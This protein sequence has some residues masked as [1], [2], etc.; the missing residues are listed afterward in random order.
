MAIT[1][2]ERVG[3]A[4]DLLRS[5]LG[6]LAERE[7][8]NIHSKWAE[9]VAR[10]YFWT[11]SRLSTN[12]PLTEWDSAAPLGLTVLSWGDAFRQTLGHAERSLV[13]EILDWRNEWAHQRRF[14]GDDAERALDSAVRLLTAISAPQADEASRMR[15]ELR[16]L[17]INEQVELNIDPHQVRQAVTQRES[18]NG[19]V[20]ARL[21]G[22]YCWVLAP[23]QKELSANVEWQA[24][25]LAG[26]DPLAVRAGA[27]RR[28]DGAVIANFGPTLLQKAIDDVPLWR[29]EDHVAVRTLVDDF[30]QRLYLQRLAGPTVLTDSLRSGMA[31]LTRQLD[32][33][34]Y[35]KS[36][37]ADTERYIGLRD[38]QQVALPP[39]DAGLILRPEIAQCHMKVDMPRP[40]PDDEPGASSED[41]TADTPHDTGM[42]PVE[43]S[44]G[45]TT[46]GTPR[47][48]GAVDVGPTRV[49]GAASQIAEKVGA[50]LV[51]SSG[52]EVTV[53]IEIAARLP[54]GASEL[55]VR[56]VTESGHEMEFEPGW[57]FERE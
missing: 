53:T 46:Q 15:G 32:A 50:H 37:D 51:G 13:S 34:D 10:S 55:S 16:Q 18:A 4:A 27:R 6:P 30:A 2:R 9:Q 49:G 17:V 56:T 8:V 33:C 40:S 38:G 41:G 21:P 25:R 57:G 39:D 28:R 31:L 42:V 22:A 52:A 54:E 45:D 7:C 20:T 5:G 14:S 11:E 44:R 24:T 47:Y 1:S 26:S 36:L 23:A 43:P 48:H 12:G 35:A 29:G 19:T 3:K